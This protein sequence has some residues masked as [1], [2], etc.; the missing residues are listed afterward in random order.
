MRLNI[1]GEHI[2]TLNHKKEL[3]PEINLVIEIFITAYND[4][5]NPKHKKSAIDFFQ[6]E[7]CDIYAVMINRTGDE[8]CRVAGMILQGKLKPPLK[9]NKEVA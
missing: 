1:I 7:L 9:Q 2:N 8:M 4:L 3:T 6:S 5:M